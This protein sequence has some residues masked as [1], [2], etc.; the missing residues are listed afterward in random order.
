[1][2]KPILEVEN[3]AK[4]FGDFKAVNNISFTVREGEIVGLL[5]PNGAGKTTTIQMLLGLMTPTRGEISY[6]G[7]SFATH[8]EA[9]LQRINHT[10]GYARLPWR[11]TVW[12]NLDVYCYLYQ[13]PNHRQ[14]IT[15][16]AAI[17]EIT[18]L[19][20]KKIQDLSA[21]Q[22][23]RVLL[24]KAFLN[25]PQ[26]LLLDEPTASLDPDIADKIRSYIL[27]ERKKR[28]LS[29]LVTSHNMGEVEELCD[30]VVFL[31]HGK[32]LAIDTPLGLA[33]RNKQSELKLM[34]SDGLKRLLE[35]TNKLNYR[36][37]EKN[38]FVVIK[39]PESQVAAFL[40]EVGKLGVE[41][42]EIEIVRPSL[43]DFFLS[44]THGRK[45]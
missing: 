22:S 5:G 37:T 11:L 3:L 26:V 2:D 32:I 41:F 1:M 39:L 27:S 40:T 44:V 4:I 31:D 23:T 13:V 17:F 18:D 42:S 38:R 20:R 36:Y 30:R 43:E 8:R 34:I 9:I 28:Q 45:L 33:R 25:D 10:S 24:T 12:E 35:M 15:E 14:K 29:I 19:L 16:L 7:E 6:F 21:G